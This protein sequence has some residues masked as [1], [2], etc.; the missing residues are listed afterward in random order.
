MVGAAGFEPAQTYFKGRC[1]AFRR[2]PITRWKG[3]TVSD[4]SCVAGRE[5]LEPPVVFWTTVLETVAIAAMRPP[6]RE[7][8]SGA[9]SSQRLS[10]LMLRAT[11][12]THAAAK[13][14]LRAAGLA[15]LSLHQV[16][17]DGRHGRD[18]RSGK[19]TRSTG[20]VADGGLAVKIQDLDPYTLCMSAGTNP[21]PS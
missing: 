13:L 6:Y 1:P 2:R 14:M 15:L 11:P 9:E 10:A 4:A 21:S 7:E 19:W 3:R 17:V 5:G 12:T 8:A 18:L 20:C 16:A